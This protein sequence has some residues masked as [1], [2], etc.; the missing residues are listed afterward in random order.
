MQQEEQAPEETPDIETGEVTES[1][2][3]EE[4]AGKGSQES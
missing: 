2:D 3:G 1:E 4:E